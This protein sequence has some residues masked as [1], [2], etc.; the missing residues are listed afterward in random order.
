VNR[1]N[2]W[3][4]WALVGVPGIGGDPRQVLPLPRFQ[5][6]QREPEPLHPRE[7]LRGDPHVAVELSL[8]VSEPYVAGLLELSHAHLPGALAK[9]ADRAGDTRIRSEELVVSG[10]YRWVRNPM[11]LA[12]ELVTVGQ[13]LLLR[14]AWLLVYA[15]I[16]GAAFAAFV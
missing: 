8:E 10:L 3:T 9:H 6:R 5:D 1:L 13:A 7:N 12:V 14:Q 2:S 4:K 16:V 11:Y 15:T